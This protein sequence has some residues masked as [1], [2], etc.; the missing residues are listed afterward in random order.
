[1]KKRVGI[2]LGVVLVCIVGIVLFQILGRKS[3]E[4]TVIES[5]SCTHERF[6]FEQEGRNIYLDCI[7]EITIEKNGQK[8]D[9]K[10]AILRNV[11]TLDEV[12]DNANRSESYWDGGTVEYFYDDFKIIAYQK[13]FGCND[14]VIGNID[15]E[16]KE[17]CIT[18]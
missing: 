16:M 1:M 12:F 9:F 6:Y 11:I 14:I 7:E 15:M 18:K 8:Y 4:F 13:T 2:I 3:L 5:T 10:D 17:D